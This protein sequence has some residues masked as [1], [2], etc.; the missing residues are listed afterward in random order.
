MRRSL[1][2]IENSS[3]SVFYRASK[4]EAALFGFSALLFLWGCFRM[5]Q[6]GLPN[7]SGDAGAFLIGVLFASCGFFLSWYVANRW[8]WLM[9]AV[10]IVGRMLLLPMP[11]S[12]DLSRRL[13]EGDVLNTNLNPYQLEPS[14]AE[15]RL[16]RD[17]RWERIEDKDQVSSQAPLVLAVFRIFNSMGFNEWSVKAVFLV[18]DIWICII[19]ALRYGSKKAILYGWNPLAAYFIAGEGRVECLF[20]LPALGGYL[21]WEAWVDRK[22]GAVVIANNGGLGGGPGQMVS[23]AALLVGLSIAMNIIFLPILVWMFWHVL[24][25]SGLRTGLAILTIGLVPAFCFSGWGAYSLGADMRSLLPFTLPV[26]EGALSLL[27][28]VF[29]FI[30]LPLKPNLSY[31]AIVLIA[32]A[33]MVRNESLGRY[34]NLYLGVYFVFAAAIAPWQFLWLAPFAVGI[35]QLGFRLVS[36]SAFVYF[37]AFVG[38]EIQSALT[39]WQSWALWA[40]LLFG[41]AWYAIKGRSKT[42]GLY[43]RSY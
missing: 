37:F 13:W 41:L 15:L 26:D 4:R 34:S 18:V 27:P 21:I 39:I 9:I 20:L 40:P 5:T 32:F 22:G 14:S 43:V 24:S 35:G 25:K 30:G 2:Y 17:R 10:A 33:L 31:S 28:N 7:G 8:F 3:G 6:A 12:E 11:S 16:L 29:E 42:D 19:L 36:I 23:F 38:S 1:A